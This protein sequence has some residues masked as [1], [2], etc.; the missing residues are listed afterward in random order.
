MFS[1]ERRGWAEYEPA[2]SFGVITSWELIALAAI[3]VGSHA[4]ARYNYLL[5]HLSVELFSAC[6]A[7]SIFIVGVSAHAIASNN[8]VVITGITYLF[9]AILDVLH[10]FS[11]K[12][13]P[14]FNDY[15]YYGPQFWIAA[16]YLEATGLLAAIL[17]ID[18]RR[19]FNALA[20]FGLL[21][22]ITAALILSILTFRIFPICFVPGT[23]LTA[24]K[25][26]S[27]YAIVGLYAAS[28]WILHQKRSAFAKHVYELLRLSIVLM[29]LME[30]CF[31]FYK[32]DTMSD[33]CNELGHLIKI[34]S[35]YLLCKAFVIASLRD[36]LML[37]SRELRDSEE[38]QRANA[39]RL[40]DILDLQRDIASSNLEYS[41]LLPFI[42]DRMTHLVACDGACLELCDN[43]ELVYEA[44]T[45]LAAGFVGLR[46]K[47]GASLS[48]LSMTSNTILRAHDTES[49]PR[50]DREACRRV[51]MRSMIVMPLRYDERSFGV[52]KLLSA[53]A[54]AFTSSADETLR[55]M[56]EFLGVTI[57]RQR[58]QAAL[59][60]SEEQF[61][62]LADAIP[63]LAWM[64][65][66]DG[67]VTWYNRRWYEQTGATPEQMEGWGWQTVHY[68]ETLPAVLERWKYSLATGEPFDMVF[69]LRGADG[70]FRRFLTRVQPLKNAEGRVVRW[71]GT[72]TNVDELKRIEEALRE[73]E[74]HIR[75]LLREVNH[76][77][78]NMLAVVQAIARQTVASSSE[79]FLPRFSERIHSLA[80]AQD[81]LIKNEWKGAE[82]GELVRSQLSHFSDWAGKRITLDG[83]ALFLTAAASQT[84]GMALHELAT[85]AGKYGALSNGEGRVTIEWRLDRSEQAEDTFSIAWTES[86][87]PAVEAPK[88]QGFGSTVV[89]KLAEMKLAAKVDL[90][91]SRA[92][93]RWRLEC[94][95]AEILQRDN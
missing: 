50:V 53:N 60:E 41:A 30:V 42:L 55:L 62:T 4:L 22:A 80:A 87:G 43:E 1:N 16:R 5:F 54:G 18:A 10:A 65:N 17:S 52:L 76:R 47:I 79:D 8:F 73:S 66:A 72:N 93:L 21:F 13:M 7:F 11:Y 88:R 28:L 81:L 15:G 74:E 56:Q 2:K 23:G 71:F 86:G 67:W 40:A 63:Q 29:A 46:V 64:A 39:K 83:P 68:P 37:V 77:S 51:G 35:F 31:T 38:R 44:A 24:F 91:F 6:I 58:A 27:E 3:I 84:I 95:A 34:F 48:G 12:G 85:N 33:L 70:V 20:I 89:G 78:K 9:V 36:P 92:G 49:D 19:R 32:S 25:V 59:Q 75:L 45:G 14:F 94:P 57:A 90:S 69:P 82:V 61:R 26:Y